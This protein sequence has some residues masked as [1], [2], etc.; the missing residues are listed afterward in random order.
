MPSRI[1]IQLRC[2]LAPFIE[3][4][5]RMVKGHTD[6]YI[7]NYNII[8]LLQLPGQSG[9]LYLVAGVAVLLINFSLE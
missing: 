9:Y 6:S 2:S 8:Q 3:P 5:M 4:P 1:S 7:H